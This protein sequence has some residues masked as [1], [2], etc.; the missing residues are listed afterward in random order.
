M[1]RCMA[2]SCTSLGNKAEVACHTLVFHVECVSVHSMRSVP[3]RIFAGNGW[4]SWIQCFSESIVQLRHATWA[5]YSTM[6]AK[7]Y[8]AVSIAWT[9]QR[10]HHNLELINDSIV[11]DRVLEYDLKICIQCNAGHQRIPCYFILITNSIAKYNPRIISSQI[12][13]LDTERL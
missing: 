5:K 13:S 2:F 4:F 9:D 3:W 11:H 7:Y 8:I 10:S 6:T 12:P 1:W